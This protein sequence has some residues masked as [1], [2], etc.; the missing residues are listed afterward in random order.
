MKHQTQTNSSIMHR[1]IFIFLLLC[2]SLGFGQKLTLE[3]CI[4]IALEKNISIKQADLEVE[5][6]KVGQSDARSAFLPSINLQSNHSWNIGLNSN[7]TTGILENLTTQFTSISGSV[8]MTIYNGNRNFLQLY[9]SN[10]DL[11]ARE[12]QLQDMSDDVRLLIANAFLQIMFNDEILKVSK[13]QLELSQSELER[14][15][16]LI[17]SGVLAAGDIYEIQ[18]TV[19]SQEQAL[20]N[21][22]NNLRLSKINLAQ[23]LLIQDYENFDIQ[24]QDLEVPFS[25]ITTK[26]PKAIY[27]KALEFRNDIR[28]AKTNVEITTADIKLIKAEQFPRLTGFYSYNTRISYSDQRVPNGNFSTQPIGYIESTG[29]SVLTQVPE[30]SVV[31]PPSFFDQWSLYDGHNFGL[32]LSIPVFNQNSVK[33]RITRSKINLERSQTLLDQQKLDLENTI[34][35]AYNNTK[36]A[37]KI[38]E[39]AQTTLLAREQAYK[40]AGDRLEAGAINSFEFIQSKQRYEEAMSNLVR[41]KFDYIFKLKVLEFY[42]GLPVSLNP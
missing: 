36:G 12:Y 26:S 19:A 16:N 41:A 40:N 31:G 1:Y 39:A 6:A 9:R 2:T 4:A 14:T 21:A 17:T 23:L 18:A 13:T 25:E 38:Y 8:G 33:N 7:I 29:E 10:L 27:E 34:N 42:F 28:A 22:E 15:R 11:L 35:Q 37:F 32:Q 5:N 30:F 24:L 20:I 3:Q